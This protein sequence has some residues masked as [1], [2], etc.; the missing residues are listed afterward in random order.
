MMDF[1]NDTPAAHGAE[2][3]PG[4]VSRRGFMTLTTAGLVLPM[5]FGVTTRA[6][7]A[8]S[9]A[10][11]MLG[12]YVRIGTDNTVTVVIGS[13]EMGQGIMTG[14][15]QLVG[16]ELQVSWGQM[17]AEHAPASALWPNPYGNPIFGAQLTGGS[18]SMMG[19]YGPMRTAA[20]IVRDTLLAAAAKKY[21]GTW[22]LTS[23]GKVTDGVATHK[24]S[25][26]L[27]VAATITP[28]TTATLA[29][30]KKF[31]GKT[32]QRLDIP[33]K[34]DG[35][36]VFGMDVKVDGMLFATVV[37][38]PVVGSTVKKMP[39][40]VAH[41]TLVNLGSTVGVVSSDTW[42]AMN[43]AKPM[44]IDRSAAAAPAMNDPSEALLVE[45]QR[46]LAKRGY[47][48]GDPDGKT[49]P[50]TTQAIRDFQFAQRVAIDGRP[51]E[52][53]LQSV[54][55]TK[56]TM[57]DELL[58]LVRKAGQP[59]TPKGPVVDIQ[60]ALNKAGY[61]P[62]EEDGHMGPSTKQ[63]LARFEADK[64]LPPRGEPKGPVLNLLASATGISLRQP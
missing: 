23:G 52:A 8:A 12:A 63:A 44:P 9:A 39:T 11:V 49:G 25:D 7:E 60:R 10:P 16:E 21:G 31:I 38:P 54:L 19:W 35:S 14:L 1:P 50:R 41:A 6:A 2:A 15:A 58:D 47:Y 20:A 42:T 27:D 18:T 13:T 3:G 53:L 64:K 5:V 32:M 57:K 17:R 30:T 28:P 43:A 29:T 34:V 62:L 37:H 45:I 46:E 33:P 36:A 56:V 26:L 51:S 4:T 22:T 61:G 55:A 24:F 59:E 48:K 40:S